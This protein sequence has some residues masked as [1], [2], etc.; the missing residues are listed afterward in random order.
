[1]LKIE[2][3]AHAVNSTKQNIANKNKKK[4]AFLLDKLSSMCYITYIRKTKR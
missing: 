2:G 1:M 4:F 3:P